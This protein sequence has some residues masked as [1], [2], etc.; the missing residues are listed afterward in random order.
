M[1]R[2]A[3][4]CGPMEGAELY[5]TE[6]GRMEGYGGVSRACWRGWRNSHLSLSSFPMMRSSLFVTALPKS[7]CCEDFV[8]GED[9]EQLFVI[10]AVP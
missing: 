4:V 3:T 9:Q 6:L 5:H 1:T 7:H 8:L 2:V 10:F